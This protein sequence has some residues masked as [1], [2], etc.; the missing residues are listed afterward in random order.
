VKVDL[1]AL[2]KDLGVGKKGHGV[3]LDDHAPLSAIRRAITG[4]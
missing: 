4:G 2:W 3:I 1:P